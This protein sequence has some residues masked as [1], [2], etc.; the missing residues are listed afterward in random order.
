M[1]NVRFCLSVLLVLSGACCANTSLASDPNAIMVVGNLVPNIKISGWVKSYTYTTPKGNSISV[2]YIHSITPVDWYPG[3]DQPNVNIGLYFFPRFH[4][5][6]IQIDAFRKVMNHV[7]SL[8]RGGK[9]IT[10]TGTLSTNELHAAPA[11]GP[12]SLKIAPSKITACNHLV[13]RK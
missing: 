3:K 1:K 10:I 13:I 7:K 8:S 11:V 12:E 6:D 9:C 2:T 5:Y 4:V